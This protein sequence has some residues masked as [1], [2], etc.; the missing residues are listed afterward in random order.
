MQCKKCSAVIPDGSVFCCFC[1]KKQVAGKRPRTHKRAA[2]SGTISKDPRCRKNPYTVRA[3]G[4]S[5]G[6]GRVYIGSFPDLLSAQKALEDYMINGRPELYNATLGDI[7]RLWSR[8]HYRTVS[9][10]A[11]NLY[12]SMFKKFAPLYGRKMADLRTVDFQQIVD[13]AR[14]KSAAGTLKVLAILLS[15]FALENDV[16][17]KNYAEFIKIPKFEKKEKRIFSAEEIQTL[18]EHTDDRRVQAVLFMIYMGF[19][20][21]E[22]VKL[23]VSDVHLDEGYIT[24]G[25]KT[26]AGRGRVVPFPPNIPLIRSFVEGWIAESEGG[27]LFE[28]TSARFREDVFYGPLIELGLV[29]MNEPRHLTPH[30]TRHTFASLSA[31]AGMRPD[32]LQKII[33][34]AN[35]Q[36]TANVYIHKDIGTLRNAMTALKKV[37]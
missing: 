25:E 1:G 8:S 6:A 17:D 30:S 28:M 19:R 29:D 2:G 32:E 4:T 20:I 15:R 5:N 36:T 35:Y 27:R 7:Y 37:E 21:G 23:R 31:E 3:P 18:W 13:G 16:I 24:G 14:S 34:H 11:V 26:E 22:V 9:E 10:S 12:T 33:G